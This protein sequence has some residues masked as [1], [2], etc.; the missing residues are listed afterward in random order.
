MS[1]KKKPRAKQNYKASIQNVIRKLFESNPDLRYSHKQVCTSLDIKENAL[2]KLTFDIL[3]GFV[4]D[5][6]LKAL[7]HGDFQYNQQSNLM[8]GYLD[9][10]TRGAGFVNI[11]DLETDVYISP[12]NVGHSLPGDLVKIQIIKKGTGRWEGIVVDVVEREMTQVVG[13]IEMH[14]KF[15]FLVPNNTRLGKDL[16]I[17]KKN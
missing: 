16:Y 1:K 15:A 12:R 8:I 10:T 9:M 13:T 14:E 11:D 2:R 4:K 7:G 6:F 3:Q 17:P 5:D